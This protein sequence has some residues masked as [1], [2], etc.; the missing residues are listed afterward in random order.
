ME[1]DEAP[2]EDPPGKDRPEED[3]PEERRYLRNGKSQGRIELRGVRR[4]YWRDAYHWSLNISW[5]GFGALMAMI[6]LAVSSVFGLLFHLA[7][8]CLSGISRPSYAADFKFSMT[9]LASLSVGTIAPI[10]LYADSLVFAESFLRIIMLAL[11][12]GVIFARISR[13]TARIRFT[14]TA[15]ITLFEGRPTFMFRVGNERANIILEAEVNVVLA[16]SV[17]TIE[18]QRIR[19]LDEVRMQRTRTPLFAL[20]W[21]VL[22]DI[23]ERSPLHDATIDSL[24]AQEAEIIV[25]LSGLDEAFAQ[26]VHARHSYSFGEIVFDRYFADVVRF[27]QPQ[28]RWIVD[29]TSFDRFQSPNPDR[30]TPDPIRT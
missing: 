28:H 6:Y 27:D 2:E 17:T 29:Y 7:P 30:P 10:G 8:G 5:L 23:D 24:R 9:T 22:H 4:T 11:A 12:T 21:T 3:R 16:R 26:R 13:P 25:V 15:L 14:S 19:R 18:G 1:H 20:T